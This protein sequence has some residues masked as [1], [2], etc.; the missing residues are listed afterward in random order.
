MRQQKVSALV[1]GA[2]Q[3]CSK[4]LFS[5]WKNPSST[6]AMAVASAD[7]CLFSGAKKLA[8]DRQAAGLTSLSQVKS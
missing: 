3:D 4:T 2:M 8:S 6:S 5:P 7:C 1:G